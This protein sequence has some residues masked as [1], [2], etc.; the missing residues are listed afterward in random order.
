VKEGT[1]WTAAL[2]KR[3]FNKMTGVQPNHIY[4]C[5]ME[6]LQEYPSTE[7]MADYFFIKNFTVFL[8]PFWS[9]ISIII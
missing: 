1:W 4:P 3:K 7:W 5:M 2:F 8:V 9:K 6:L